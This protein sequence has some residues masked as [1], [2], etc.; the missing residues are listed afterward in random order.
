MGSRARL[1]PL[2]PLVPRPTASLTKSLP[3]LRPSPPSPRLKRLSPLTS[4]RQVA[5]LPDAQSMRNELRILS[6]LNEIP[7]RKW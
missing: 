1:P 2:G 6:A 7:T 5:D 3:L 4:R